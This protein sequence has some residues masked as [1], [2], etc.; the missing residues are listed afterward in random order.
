MGNN[1]DVPF[2][3]DS[4]RWNPTHFLDL[5]EFTAGFAVAYDWMYDGWT[6]TQKTQIRTAIVENGLNYC[7]ASLSGASSAGAYS[8]WTGVNGQS[9]LPFASSASDLTLTSDTLVFSGNWNCVCNSGC[10]LGALAIQGDDTTGQASAVL[11]LSVPNAQ[12]NCAQA[13]HEDGT[14]RSVPLSRFLRE[15]SSSVSLTLAALGFLSARRP[16]TGSFS[17]VTRSHLLHMTHSFVAFSQVLRNDRLRRDD[18]VPHHSDRLG[19][20]HAH[21]Q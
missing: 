21:R 9:S 11:A 8:W 5:A 15:T 18:L 17:V 3:T 13:V 14:W 16:T 4:T 2:G 12:K 6:D 7:Q 1:A 20:G 10:T 19:P